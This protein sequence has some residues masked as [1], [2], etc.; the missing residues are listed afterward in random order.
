MAY[1]VI[2]RHGAGLALSNK[3]QVGGGGNRTSPTLDGPRR[4]SMI[5]D[6]YAVVA[7]AR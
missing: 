7:S 2:V 1:H 3:E 4:E 6:D 5:A